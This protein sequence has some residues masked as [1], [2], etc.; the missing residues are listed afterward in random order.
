[1]CGFFS[2]EAPLFLGHLFIPRSL[3]FV[4]SAWQCGPSSSAISR[5]P[6]AHS[7]FLRP[8]QWD[9]YLEWRNRGPLVHVLDKIKEEV[10]ARKFTDGIVSGFPCP[11]LFLPQKEMSKEVAEKKSA[12]SR[13][14]LHSFFFRVSE[15]ARFLFARIG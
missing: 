7:A 15:E 9:K 6:R 12:F 2:R 14:H 3:N 11:I 13:D 4:W 8:H 5:D 1:V 10:D